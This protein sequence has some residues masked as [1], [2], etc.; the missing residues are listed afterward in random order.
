[1]IKETDK[2]P[3]IETIINETEPHSI[4][5]YQLTDNS[6]FIKLQEFGNFVIAK[7][8]YFGM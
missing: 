7:Y 1:M 4:I 5:Y 3:L 8:F 6:K 2:I